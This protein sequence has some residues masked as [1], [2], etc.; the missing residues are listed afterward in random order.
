MKDFRHNGLI[1]IITIATE[2]KQESFTKDS[3]T[4]GNIYI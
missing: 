4:Q 1:P 2:T 3:I